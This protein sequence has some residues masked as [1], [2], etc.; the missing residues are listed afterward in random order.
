MS[1][2]LSSPLKPNCPPLP[3]RS[4]LRSSLPIS[5]SHPTPLQSLTPLPTSPPSSLAPKFSRDRPKEHYGAKERVVSR[6]RNAGH[7]DLKKLDGS[8][9]REVQDDG[10]VVERRTRVLWDRSHKITRDQLTKDHVVVAVDVEERE[11]IQPR[12]VTRE[13]T[14]ETKKVVP[15]IRRVEVPVTRKK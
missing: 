5:T 12:V 1:A 6:K 2:P 8:V 15:E 13:E 14:I 10:V 3:K 7:Y 4:S 9:S 11:I